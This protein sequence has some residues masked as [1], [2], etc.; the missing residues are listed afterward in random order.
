MPMVTVRISE[1][2]KAEIETLTEEMG[3]YNYESEFLRDAI[4]EHIK[5]FWRG[6]RFAHQPI[7]LNRASRQSP[8]HKRLGAKHDH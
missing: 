4:N 7:Y 1:G 2:M 6:E 3:I 5:K 8:E